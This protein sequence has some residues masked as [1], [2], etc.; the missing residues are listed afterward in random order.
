MEVHAKQLQTG[1]DRA[2]AVQLF[3][4]KMRTGAP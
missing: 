2:A 4:K 3:P 1:M